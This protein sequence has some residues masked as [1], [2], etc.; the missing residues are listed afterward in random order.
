MTACF[1]ASSAPACRKARRA[2]EAS[3]LYPERVWSDFTM[4]LT[5]PMCRGR[6]LDRIQVGHDRNFMGNRD[7]E[8]SEV[9]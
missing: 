1:P 7:A 5:A 8:P 2:P 4:V 3:V 9:A 6:G